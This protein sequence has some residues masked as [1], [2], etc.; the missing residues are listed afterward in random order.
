MARS[1]WPPLFGVAARSESIADS[2]PLAIAHPVA[3][4]SR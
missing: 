4:F 1:R 2:S 3:S